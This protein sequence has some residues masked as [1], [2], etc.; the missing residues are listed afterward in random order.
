[1]QKLK[2]CLWYDK[3]AAEAANF[4]CS[5]FE[6]S[7]V[8]SSNK[9]ITEFT[10]GGQDFLALN[11]GP[12]FRFTPAISMFV[13]CE[14]DNEITSLW[15]KLTDGGIVMMPLQKYDWSEKYGWL[16]DKYGLT[17]QIYKGDLSEVNSKI[18]PCFLFGD[19]R[20]GQAESAVKF[21]TSVFQDSTIEGIALYP[22]EDSYTAGKVMHSQFRLA[23][24]VF[25]AM[26]GPGEHNF[27][28]NEAFSLVVNCR[29]QQEID[30]YWSKLTEG[31]EESMCGWLKDKFGVSWQIVP[32]ILA[33]L[34]NDP[35]KSGRVTEAF[36]KMK[37]FEIDKLMLA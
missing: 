33:E 29:D 17:W 14:D 11:G 10:I 7:S 12:M 30:Y 2:P 28:F 34:M 37:K 3:V 8:R 16:A 6:D 9:L 4:Y 22:E 26:D 1:M 27:T 25:M 24:K 18:T 35:E 15:K 20:F 23:G 36:L 13:T 31:G 19:K 5:L 32:E 21:Y